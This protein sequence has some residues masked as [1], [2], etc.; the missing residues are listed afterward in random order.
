[1]SAQQKTSVDDVSAGCV[2]V[3][4]ETQAVQMA[5]EEPAG[6]GVCT[7]PHA[8]A[9]PDVSVTHTPCAV[10]AV[11]CVVMQD[12]CTVLAGYMNTVG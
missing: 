7:P 1:M 9:V 11:W 10:A 3:V 8:A 2:Q 5:T 12:G 6:C 4:G